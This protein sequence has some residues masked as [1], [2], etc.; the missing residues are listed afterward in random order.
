MYIPLPLSRSACIIYSSFRAFCASVLVCV[1]AIGTARDWRDRNISAAR[2]VDSYVTRMGE[3]VFERALYSFA[4]HVL[5][6][7]SSRLLLSRSSVLVDVLRA[8]FLR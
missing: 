5:V 7:R 3:E 6:V 2:G 1:Y 4:C 8:G